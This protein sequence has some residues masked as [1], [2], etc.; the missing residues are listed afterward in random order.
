[1]KYMMSRDISTLNSV[2]GILQKKEQLARS[3]IRVIIG[4][5]FLRMPRSLSLVFILAKEWEGL[6]QEMRFL[7]KLRYR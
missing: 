5:L 7:F 3:Y 6:F 2:V 4:P 1:M